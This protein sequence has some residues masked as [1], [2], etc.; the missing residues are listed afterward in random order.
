MTRSE[1][2]ARLRELRAWARNEVDANG[3]SDWAWRQFLMQIA[4]AELTLQFVGLRAS[5]R[6]IARWRSWFERTG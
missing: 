4:A 3:E 1:A 5:A 2:V 6:Q